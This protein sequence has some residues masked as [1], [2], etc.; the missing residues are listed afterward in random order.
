MHACCRIDMSEVSAHACCRIDMSEVS[1]HACC[2]IDMSEQH[3]RMCVV[4]YID[5]SEYISNSV[6]ECVL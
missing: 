1:A 4:E 2:R 5:M 3:L 6:C